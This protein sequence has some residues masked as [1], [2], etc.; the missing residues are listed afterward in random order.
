M[1]DPNSDIN[2]KIQ[3]PAKQINNAFR[4][5]AHKSSEVMG[6][7]GLF[8]LAVIIVG[9]WALT[10][11][12]FDFSD[13]WQLVINTGTTII[14]FLMVFVIQNTQNRDAHTMQLKLDE[15]LRAIKGAR[16]DLIDLENCSDEHLARFEAEFIRLRQ[17]RERNNQPEQ[18]TEQ[19][20]G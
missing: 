4:I 13:T 9:I 16:N 20:E 18:I 3:D 19:I 6:S 1:K 15:L 8:M 11:P 5:F 7:P 12:L 17:A 10:G 14:T 2:P